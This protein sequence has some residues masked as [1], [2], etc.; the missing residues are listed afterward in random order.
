MRVRLP[1]WRRQALLP[2]PTPPPP[3]PFHSIP[4]AAFYSVADQGEPS[5]SCA[6]FSLLHNSPGLRHLRHL[7]ARL[8]RTALYGDVVLSSKLVL[9]YS[10]HGGL[11]T[12]AYPV[13]LHMPRRND[14]SWSIIIGEMS[15]SGFPERA[16]ALFAEMR[17]L[18]VPV[19]AFTAP[20][21]LRSCATARA[22]AAG[23]AG[24]CLCVRLGL[25]GNPYV[26]S[27][28]VFLY[29]ALGRIPQARVLF[30][31][32]PRRDAVLWTTMLSGYAQRGEPEAAL[33]VFNAMVCE[34]VVLD[35][36]VM[37]SLLLACSQLGSLRHGKS[38]HG[39]ILRRCLGLGLSLRNALVD[40]YVKCGALLCAERVFSRM[41][42]R[43]VISWSSLI[44]GHGLNGH[45]H[46]A[47]ELFDKMSTDGVR[48][49]SV[50]FLGVLSACTHA[51]MVDKAWAFWDM[52][53]EHGVCP[54]LK[55]YACMV[56]VLGRAGQLLR[57]ERF[58][59]EM[60][61]EAD[62]A[63]WGALL[64]ACRIHGEVEVAE[65][66]AKRLLRL[67]PDKSGYYVLLANIYSDIGRYEDAERVRDLMRQMNVGKLPGHSSV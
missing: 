22:S 53:E 1:R 24:H 15:R 49:N 20:I 2:P 62:E 56:D 44:L 11:F 12:S 42:R 26:A 52:M 57:A 18:G 9:A 35:G 65:R 61:V 43:D 28:L 40:M 58:V 59:E 6:Y 33:A 51:G 29:V 14:Y 64:A 38:V 47:L 54:E 5:P 63:V 34:R 45:A 36:V 10:R 55:H 46:R 16:I 4:A 25:A 17:R 3:R 23:M 19:D 8:L 67:Q 7:H 13:F 30:D 60:P 50:T 32:M 21:V 39:F 48:P 66:V 37:V 27:A 31:E 41:P